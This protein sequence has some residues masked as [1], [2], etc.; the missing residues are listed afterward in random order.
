M[1]KYAKIDAA[2]AASTGLL[3]LQ[4]TLDA[5]RLQRVPDLLL[6]TGVLTTPVDVAAMVVR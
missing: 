5:R 3:T 2:T 1:V 6:K 4:S